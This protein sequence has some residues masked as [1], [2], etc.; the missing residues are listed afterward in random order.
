ENNIEMILE[1]YKRSESNY[2]FVVVGPLNTNYAGFLMKKYKKEKKIKFMNGIYDKRVLDNLRCHCRLYFHG[3]SVG[4][5]NPS[6]LEVMSC[7]TPI[8]AHENIFNRSVLGDA[9]YFFRSSDEV[10]TNILNQDVEVCNKFSDMNIKKIKN[11][12]NWSKITDSYLKLFLE[13]T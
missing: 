3:H 2:P 10:S 1:G 4:G 12:Y 6:L 9:A 7:G 13:I 8:A 5:T 11:V